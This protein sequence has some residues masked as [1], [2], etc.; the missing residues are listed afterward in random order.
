MALHFLSE[1][2]FFFRQ[3]LQ[4]LLD[5]FFGFPPARHASK[6]RRAGTKAKKSNSRSAKVNKYN[7]AFWDTLA[8]QGT[9]EPVAGNWKVIQT[10]PNDPG[11]PVKL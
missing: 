9:S 4:D 6:A 5:I 10:K 1:L 11:D 3:D 7:D 8:A 2:R